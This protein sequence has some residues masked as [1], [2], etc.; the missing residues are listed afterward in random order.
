MSARILLIE[1]DEI[2]RSIISDNLVSEGYRV[3]AVGDGE[4][5]LA[6]IRNRSGSHSSRP[7]ATWT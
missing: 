2:F 7:D 6:H 3:D 4:A 1:D 5:A